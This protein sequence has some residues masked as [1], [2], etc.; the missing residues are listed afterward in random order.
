MLCQFVDFVHCRIKSVAP[1]R[2]LS[3]FR[4]PSLHLF[5]SVSK[6]HDPAPL[7]LGLV[8]VTTQLSQVNAQTTEDLAP[9]FPRSLADT[10]PAEEETSA[11]AIEDPLAP[12]LG[13]ALAGEDTILERT[14][15]P[16]PFAAQPLSRPGAL[17]S[18][19]DPLQERRRKKSAF[20]FQI[21]SSVEYNDNVSISSDDPEGDVVIILAP[22]LSAN[23][24][25]YREQQATY[26]SAAYTATGSAYTSGST[27]DTFDHLLEVSGQWKHKKTT[28]PFQA[29]FTRESGA[30]LDLGGRDTATSYGGR[31]GVEHALSSKLSLGVSGEYAATDYELFADFYTYIADAYVK[32]H[33][34]RKT[35]LSG[36]YRYRF[37]KTEDAAGQT[38]QALLMRLDARPTAKISGLAEAGAAFGRFDNSR[39]TDLIYRLALAYQP[40]RRQRLS[41]EAIRQPDTSAFTVGSGIISNGVQLVFEQAIGKKTRLILNGGYQLQDYF[42]AEEGVSTDRKDEYLS[43]SALLVYEI[44]PHWQA[45][46]HY[47]YGNNDS[48]ESLLGFNNQR[49]GVGLT[50]T[51]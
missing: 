28:M 22:T 41:L 33:F 45:E 40:N 30:Y 42:A 47:A 34:S 35:A 38:Y 50:W 11:L 8:I 32:V 21:R 3:T 17:R 13:A 1:L 12:G 48:N 26:L 10:L 18:P 20:G 49:A 15:A 4:V 46:L 27:E 44:N 24:G 6:S 29:H 5:M 23:A 16:P 7:V 51:Y 43:F 14:T 2:I 25:D 19:K 39:R 37:S 9:P 31:L 36:V